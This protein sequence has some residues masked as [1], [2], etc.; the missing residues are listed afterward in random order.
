MI[1]KLFDL[2]HTMA[3]SYLAGFTYPWEALGGISD[4]ILALGKTLPSTYK[5]IS[6][7]VWVHESATIA[8]TAYIGAPCIVGA[9]TEIR[10]CAF[11]RSSALIGENCVIG[12]SVELKNVIIFDGAQVPHFNYVGDSI[13]GYHAHMGAGAITSN[14]KADKST[15]VIHGEACIETGR[16][17][18]GAMLGDYAEIGC[19][20]VLTPGTVIGKNSTVYPTAC[21][22]GVIPEN[23]ICKLTGEIVIKRKLEE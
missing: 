23:S 9:N 17:K 8:P 6:E 11:I 22:R 18:V 4:C 20:A 1:T 3:S 16:K 5:E 2:S 7:N 14:V 13:L 15:V 19:N 12:N 21:V 10:H